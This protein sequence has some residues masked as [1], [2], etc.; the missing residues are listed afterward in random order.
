[1]QITTTLY[2]EFSKK[3]IL[4]KKKFNKQNWGRKKKE[5]ENKVYLNNKNLRKMG[6]KWKKSTSTKADKNL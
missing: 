3:K 5:K 4:N 1:M 6:K 2:M